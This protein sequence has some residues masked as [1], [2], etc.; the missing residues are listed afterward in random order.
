MFGDAVDG[1]EEL[2]HSGDEGEL[3]RLAGSAQAFVKGAQPGVASHGAE[4]GLP[5]RHAQ[6]G[7]PEWGDGRARAGALAGMLEAGDDA[8][9]GGEGCRRFEAGGIADCCDD[10]GGGLRP[11]AVDG[12]QQAADLVGIEQILDVALDLG[13]ATTPQVEILADVPGLEHVGG[14]MVLADGP[15]C[16]L[17]QLPGQVRPDEVPPVIAQ[18]GKPARRG[19]SEGV[20][21]GILG[22]QAGGELAVEAANVAGEL[23]EI[24]KR[25]ALGEAEVD[26]TMELA[27]PVVEVLAQPVAVADQLAQAFG[28]LVM[29]MG[30][31][32]A[33]LI[34]EAG[35]P[36]ALMASVL[37]RSKLAFWKRLA[38]NGL[39][40]VTSCSAAV[41]TANRFFQ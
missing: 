30:K 4:H 38:W 6:P 12:G 22:Q 33:L 15:L 36:W 39:S 1:V 3:G 32:W 10:A 20:G 16:S 35:R 18:L 7:I 17:H 27:H 8:N 26:Q 29:Q 21:G 5:E 37:V 19:L 24:A 11:D 13:Q 25:F 23:S 40:R 34:S 28:G 31:G 2:A 9:I 41:S 14:A